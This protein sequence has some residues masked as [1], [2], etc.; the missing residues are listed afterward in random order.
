M[1]SKLTFVYILMG[2]LVVF[3][4]GVIVLVINENANKG[5]EVFE[6]YTNMVYAS[7]SN[8]NEE[9]VDEKLK[10]LK[11]T[12]EVQCKDV[13]LTDSKELV[14]NNCKV[15]DTNNKFCYYK[16]SIYD[17]DNKEYKK[18]I[19]NLSIGNTITYKAGDLVKVKVGENEIHNFYVL[20]QDNNTITAI[21][22]RN[23][24]KNV[25]WTTEEDAIEA[26]YEVEFLI[27]NREYFRPFTAEKELKKNTSTWTNA[28]EVRLPQAYELL[29]QTDKYKGKEISD[30]ETDYIEEPILN[31]GTNYC[32]QES[33]DVLLPEWLT[34]NLK[35][36][37]EI[38][39]PD[40]EVDVVVYHT[41]TLATVDFL[42]SLYFVGVSDGFGAVFL[43]E[44]LLGGIRPVIKI[45][46]S[47]I[48]E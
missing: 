48:V 25:A 45:D 12:E 31:C 29:K 47:Y 35:D 17:C 6:N 36:I 8:V 44:A 15:K 10:S 21:L 39:D 9:E 1:K 4:I 26:G 18:V 46:K 7:L 13:L 38:D 32:R 2:L 19:Q 40:L 20:E 22:D 43:D 30:W 37:E 16:D 33:Q 42:G 27:E 11:A 24:G 23:I 28:K 14:L 34:V 3:I 5:K 41:D